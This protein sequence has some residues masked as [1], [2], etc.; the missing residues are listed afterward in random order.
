MRT[1][2]IAGA[3]VAA[4]AIGAIVVWQAIDGSGD[5][6]GDD[7]GPTFVI[8]PVER[9][10]LVDEVAIRG[11]VRREEL[12]RITSPIDGQVS[13]VL[14]Q[15]GD[16][17]EAGDTILALSG[18]AAVAVPGSFSFFRQLDVGSEGPDVLQLERILATGGYL[19]G[20]V[21][22]LFTEETR[23]GLA[24][25]QA[26]RGYGGANPEREETITVSLLGGGPGY[27][28]GPRNSIGYVIEPRAPDVVSASGTVDDDEPEELIDTRSRA[29]RRRRPPPIGPTGLRGPTERP[30]APPST[31]VPPTPP[32]TTQ[33]VPS[34]LGPPR[35]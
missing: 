31:T 7:D 12:Q 23:A 14:V 29:D 33:A 26:D 11:Q 19:V 15:A 18:R 5:D 8:A 34:M 35:R 2:L 20:D 21:D 28:V 1:G 27:Q 6:D 3:V 32:P 30:T 17:I 22:D 9:R 24:E 16:T 10:T 25:W 13:A 4:I